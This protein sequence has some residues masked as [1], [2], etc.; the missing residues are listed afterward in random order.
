M[1]PYLTDMYPDHFLIPV[2]HRQY[3]ILKPGKPAWRAYFDTLEQWDHT[4]AHT[5]HRYGLATVVLLALTGILHLTP[6]PNWIAFA[7]LI[8]ALITSS[9]AYSHATRVGLPATLTAALTP[10]LVTNTTGDYI[11]ITYSH[12]ETPHVHALPE[13]IVPRVLYAAAEN[14][15]PLLLHLIRPIVPT[16]TSV[17]IPGQAPRP[18]GTARLSATTK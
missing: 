18:L 13:A 17:R 9:H 10:H 2:Q 7:A 14:D 6:A 11:T 15:A 12:D 3:A 16:A 8:A 5:S 4:R 1:L